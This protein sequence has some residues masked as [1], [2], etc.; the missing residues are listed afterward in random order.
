MSL[1]L[2]STIIAKSDQLNADDLVSGPITV[3]ITSAARGKTEE[4]PVDLALSG[5]HRPWRPC[6]TCRRVLIFAWG[7]DASKW[8]GRS[9]TLFRDPNVTWGGAKVGGIR[10]AAMSDIAE[11]FTISLAVAKGKK[12]LNKVARLTTRRAADTPPVDED[13][14][15]FAAALRDNLGLDVADCEAFEAAS[16]RRLD[17][18]AARGAF[19]AWLENGGK[20]EVLAFIA[21]T[22][23]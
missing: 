23:K 4:Q 20:A 13:R 17:T 11:A 6:K 8:V 2:S 19:Y 12:D 14:A 7:P 15:A 5:G 3:M 21:A 1:D 22:S 10:I 16:E 9:L 18:P